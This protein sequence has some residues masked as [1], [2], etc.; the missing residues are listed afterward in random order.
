M[1]RRVVGKVGE[2]RVQRVRKGC[3]VAGGQGRA[4]GSLTG[5]GGGTPG[6]DKGLKEQIPAQS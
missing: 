5:R 6:Q 2:G 4:A 1:P 3:G